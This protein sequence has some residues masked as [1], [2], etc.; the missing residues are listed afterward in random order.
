MTNPLDRLWVEL[1]LRTRDE[2]VFRQL[3]NRHAQVLWRLA[4]KLSC[5]DT[6]AADDIC[7]TAWLRAV[8]KLADFR[9]D[10]SLRTWLSGFVI[11]VWREH[12]RQKQFVE[13]GVW[14]ETTDDAIQTEQKMDI[15]VAFA[16][17]PMG[18]RA[19]LTL[20]DWEGFKH[21]EIADLLDITEGTS[22]S[23]LFHARRAFRR[24]LR[25]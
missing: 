22:K 23:Q 12:S 10:A 2:T 14:D 11:N 20:H 13:I 24:R 7:Q 1:Y 19:V 9:W 15:Q 18:Y 8:E 3:Y 5:G 6:R 17:L 21:H 4:I 16:E 25:L